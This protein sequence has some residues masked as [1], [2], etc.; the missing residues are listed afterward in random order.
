MSLRK[1]LRMVFVCCGLEVGALAGVP[2]R[3]EQIEELMHQMN[4]PKLAH[5]LPAEDEDGGDPPREGTQSATSS[6]CTRPPQSQ[7]DR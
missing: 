4:V 6:Q 7:G 5:A 2:M 1:I 3:P